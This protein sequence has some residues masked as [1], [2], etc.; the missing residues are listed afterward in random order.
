MEAECS[1]KKKM[2][3]LLKWVERALSLFWNSS[4]PFND[5]YLSRHPEFRFQ[6]HK[7]PYVLEYAESGGTL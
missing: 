5:L 7:L 2:K 1:G 4:E 3:S 6:T